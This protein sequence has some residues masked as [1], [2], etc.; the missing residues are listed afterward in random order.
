MKAAARSPPPTTRSPR[1]RSL[2]SSISPPHHVPGDRGVPPR[3][4]EGLRIDHLRHV[5]PDPG[6][7]LHVRSAPGVGVGGRPESGH[8]LVGDPSV[9]EGSHRLE[10]LDDV[11]VELVIEHVPID[12]LLR[13]LEEAVQGNLDGP[14]NRIWTP[15]VKCVCVGL[16]AQPSSSPA[17]LFPP[18]LGSSVTRA[19]RMA[20]E[21]AQLE[22]LL[23]AHCEEESISGGSTASPRRRRECPSTVPFHFRT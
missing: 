19:Q 15:P 1:A 14:T 21:I 20:A 23:A 5:P 7:L 10:L 17:V 16:N 13:S 4:G 3:R 18:N 2:S 22:A 11:G 12:L 9:Q 6:E 8:E